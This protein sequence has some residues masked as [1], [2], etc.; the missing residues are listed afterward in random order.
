MELDKIDKGIL[1]ELDLNA[2]KTNKEIG[3]TLKTSE[4]IVAYRIKRMTEKGVIDGF[5]TMVNGARFGLLYFRIYFRLQ[6]IDLETEKKLIESF[7]SNPYTTWVVSV[8]GRYDFVVSM[9]AKSVEHFS[10]ELNR[11][12]KDFDNFI[13]SKNISIVEQA[14]AFTRTHLKGDEGKEIKLLYGGSPKKSNTTKNDFELLRKISKHGRMPIAEMARFFNT[15]GETISYRIK[16]LKKQKVILGFRV[17]PNLKLAGYQ[18][19]IILLS[20]H[21]LT[22]ADEK[23]LADFCLRH[24]NI[25]FYIKCIGSHEADLEIEVENEEKFDSLF[26]ELK[27]YFPSIIKD[28]EIL[29]ISQQHKFDYFGLEE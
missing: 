10:A 16:K 25:L 12:T 23:K 15:S 24:P 1:F 14:Q 11:I 6:N 2:R 8:R 4:A 22:R 28:Y 26:N 5:Y 7:A 27:R 29:S 19:Y 20:L 13:L 3:K 21:S 18:H 17:L 9:Y